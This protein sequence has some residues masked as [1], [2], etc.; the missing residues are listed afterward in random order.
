[1]QKQVLAIHDISCMG[2]CSLT[3]AL[4]ILSANGIYT[5]IL[6]TA[7]LSTH[8]AGFSG[9]TFID[10]TE[11][12]KQTKAH[13]EKLLKETAPPLP[14]DGIYTG[15]LGS[16]EQIQI[17]IDVINAFK[18]SE[19]KIIVDPVMGDNGKLFPA[20]NQEYAKEMAKLC[21]H[22]DYIIPNITEAVF[23]TNVSYKEPPY[24]LEYLNSLFNALDKKFPKTKALITGAIFESASKEKEIGS[25]MREDLKIKAI[26]HKYYDEYFHGAGDVFGSV[27]T[28]KIIN[29]RSPEEAARFAGDFTLKSIEQT[30]KQITLYNLP[31]SYARFGLNFEQVLAEARS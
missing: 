17:V 5:S 8:T 1:M 6:P 4:P 14:L 27:F 19:T 9:Y 20:F 24:N 30:K 29:G 16:K 21:A 22:A 31:S 12:M 7:L 28:A 3:V 10:L 15:Y 18:T 25:V 2:R 13:W 26:N 11:N 23:L